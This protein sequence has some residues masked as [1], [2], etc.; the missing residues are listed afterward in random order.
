[1][2]TNTEKLVR[3][4]RWLAKVFILLQLPIFVSLQ[5]KEKKQSCTKLRN[6]N[7]FMHE[8]YILF[9]Q[10][11][12]WKGW[13]K[14]FRPHEPILC[15]TSFCWNESCK[16]LGLCRYQL[17]TSRDWSFC[18]FFCAKQLNLSQ[19][20]WRVWSVLATDSQIWWKSALTWMV[21]FAPF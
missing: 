3:E 16:F 6:G 9:L 19:I 18:P 14:V 2:K 21:D 4:I 13:V 15:I 12:T 10:I 8:L 20:I 1:M 17:C 7:R 11:Q 5:P